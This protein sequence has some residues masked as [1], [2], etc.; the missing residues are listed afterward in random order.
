MHKQESP[1]TDVD[2]CLENGSEKWIFHFHEKLQHELV[3][4]YY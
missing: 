3:N 4:Y 1:M 2:M